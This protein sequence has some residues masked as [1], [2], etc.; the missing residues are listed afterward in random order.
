[1]TED[2]VAD[3]AVRYLANFH[4]IAAATCLVGSLAFTIPTIHDALQSS[5]S[6][7]VRAASAPAFLLIATGFALLAYAGYNP[8]PWGWGLTLVIYVG[9]LVV[10]IWMGIHGF[11]ASWAAVPAA[12]FIVLVFLTRD[13][14]RLHGI[15]ESPP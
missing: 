9:A 8:R 14:R 7:W 6:S 4:A 5:A 13:V 1:M 10:A 12:T 11:W 3:D 15:G 2:D